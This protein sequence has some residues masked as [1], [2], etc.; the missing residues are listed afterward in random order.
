[1][2]LELKDLI[3][4]F[5]MLSRTVPGILLPRGKETVVHALVH[6]MFP[7]NGRDGFNQEQLQFIFRWTH[8]QLP[9]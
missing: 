5:H 3:I 9:K 7:L 2:G 6:L 8:L 1:P 4:I